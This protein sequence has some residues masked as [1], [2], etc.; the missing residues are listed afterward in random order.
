MFNNAA[1]C[2]SVSA[3]YTTAKNDIRREFPISNRFQMS[4]ISKCEDWFENRPFFS[5]MAVVGVTFGMMLSLITPVF[6]TSDDTYMKGI[7]SGTFCVAEASELMVYSHVLIG[8]LLKALYAMSP[9]VPWYA[10]YL[11]G[12]QSLSY[13]GLLWAFLLVAP[14]WRSVCYFIIAMVGLGS[15]LQW[16]LA[17]TTTA[18]LAVQS[19]IVLIVAQEFASKKT[20]VPKTSRICYGMF[21]VV[22]GS[23]IR[24]QMF[25]MVS[26]L[27]LPLVVTV[28]LLQ[29]SHKSVIRSFVIGVLAVAV[30]QALAK[31]DAMVYQSDPA[32]S[33]YQRLNTYC[34]WIGDLTRPRTLTTRP[35]EAQEILSR[36]GWSANDFHLGHAWFFMDR[37]V[38][39][40][41]NLREFGSAW[42]RLQSSS[43]Q[44]VLASTIAMCWLHLT[45]IWGIAGLVIFI[46]GCTRARR[47]EVRIGFLGVWAFALGIMCWLSA[48]QK[49]PERVALSAIASAAISSLLIECLCRTR[50][51]PT[52]IQR[53]SSRSTFVA[54]S[55]ILILLTMH[56]RSGYLRQC[57][58]RKMHPQFW[59]DVDQ[60]AKRQDALV[61]MWTP[62][63]YS[64]LLPY[65]D[66]SPMNEISKCALG[67]IERSPHADAQLRA[68]GVS[69]LMSTI[70]EARSVAIIGG[71]DQLELLKRFIKEHYGI[72]IGFKLAFTG[73]TG[74][75][76]YEC[77]KMSSA[78]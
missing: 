48:T 23:M 11:Q 27:S 13:V 51:E 50:T 28:C 25:A 58:I 14:K 20:I 63:P 75:H 24:W 72:E 65:D 45:S 54:V 40:E 29:R 70:A 10:L 59:A 62:C 33:D 55:F 44:Y 15:H 66:L 73:D 1:R 7:V 38:Y 6:D 60:V 12:A 57:E 71:P 22:L 4:Q 30:V 61:V 19:G 34:Y 31:Y 77:F 36:V 47:W 76:L 78:S 21:L 16:H 74:F 3:S 35:V 46:L 8:R 43:R 39:S 9:A 67:A 56:I 52:S 53:H 18:F 41:E 64:L 49:L 2:R 42:I 69:N 68:V 32:W 37:Q 26:L 5:A 17:F